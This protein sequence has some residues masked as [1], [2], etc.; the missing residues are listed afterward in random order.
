MKP[1]IT[2]TVTE[3]P[4][5]TATSTITS[6]TTTQCACTLQPYVTSNPS[7][8]ASAICGAVAPPI[9]DNFYE[10]ESFPSGN[11]GLD[12]CGT[13]AVDYN[14]VSFY[15]QP[16]YCAF[17]DGTVSQL[18]VVG[19]TSSDNVVYYDTGCFMTVDPCAS[20]TPV[21]P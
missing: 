2:P 5:V 12:Q 21:A 20:S 10:F 7:P 13:V 6:T 17:F 3:I 4:T 15:Y 19:T 8:P 9:Y 18:G 16:G 11:D 1:Q 14:A